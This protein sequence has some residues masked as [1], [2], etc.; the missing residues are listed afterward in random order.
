[1]SI[2]RLAVT[3]KHAHAGVSKH[4]H[5]FTESKCWS[6]RTS[7]LDKYLMLLWMLMDSCFAYAM[8]VREFWKLS[9]V[10]CFTI[11]VDTYG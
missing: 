10:G 2:G 4:T 1:M 6:F 11:G 3:P 9:N 5:T 7:S 8:N